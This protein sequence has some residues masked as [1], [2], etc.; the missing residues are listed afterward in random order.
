MKSNLFKIL[1]IPY[2]L[3]FYN[4]R[5]ILIKKG[6][7]NQFFYKEFKKLFERYSFE[8][9][10][11]ENLFLI[12]ILS[13]AAFC[14]FI[15]IKKIALNVRKLIFIFFIF[16]LLLNEII[17]IFIVF[18]MTKKLNFNSHDNDESILIG[19][20]A[21]LGLL[22]SNLILA[23]SIDYKKKKA[24]KRNVSHLASDL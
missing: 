5:G 20:S 1:L 2:F 3:I 12:L 7:S 11:I 17:L 19:Y 4:V 21:L 18:I 24:N 9:P 15:V 8:E 23:I 22:I 6:Y 13:I 10:L 16:H 14:I